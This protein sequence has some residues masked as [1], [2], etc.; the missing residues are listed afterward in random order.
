MKNIIILLFLTFIFSCKESPVSNKE[1]TET[2]RR[3]KRIITKPA[4]GK[5]YD[6]T[7]FYYDINS[8]LKSISSKRN[9]E[10]NHPF[11]INY[12]FSYI[13]VDSI[14]INSG[15][16]I[17]S[18]KFI[19]GS[20]IKVHIPE[21][22]DYDYYFSNNKITQADRTCYCDPGNPQKETY[23]YSWDNSVIEYSYRGNDPS[24]TIA[25]FEYNPQINTPFNRN[26]Y[27]ETMYLPRFSYFSFYC[28]ANT[29]VLGDVPLQNLK[30]I[31]NYTNNFP[32]SFIEYE[33]EF[34]EI[35]LTA[36]INEKN[37]GVSTQST[38]LYFEEVEINVN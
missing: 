22:A 6:S 5:A 26:I 25:V 38:T 29:T 2:V 34:N 7:E 12:G 36:V 23:K 21:Y 9:T 11:T 32:S 18:I 16:E 8:K 14:T 35:G 19:I 31:T 15:S 30:K 17:S 3:I 1:Q 28:H 37:N 33:Y 24:D 4:S 13:G 20:I 10:F 27:I